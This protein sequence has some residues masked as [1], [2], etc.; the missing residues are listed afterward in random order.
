MAGPHDKPRPRCLFRADIFVG[1]TSPVCENRHHKQVK[2]RAIRNCACQR[3]V[4]DCAAPLGGAPDKGDR[5]DFRSRSDAQ[6]FVC[7]RRGRSGG[8]LHRQLY[9]VPLISQCGLV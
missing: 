7:P 4:A 2:L 8:A 3:H 1:L 9:F 6:G 5:V